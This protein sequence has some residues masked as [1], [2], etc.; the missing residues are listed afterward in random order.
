MEMGGANSHGAVVAREYGIPAVVGV[1]GATSLLS[2]GQTVT[3][4]GT[5]GVI[6][7]P[8]APAGMV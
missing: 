7:T 1:H 2:T 5:N 3:V 8:T 6:T 4:D